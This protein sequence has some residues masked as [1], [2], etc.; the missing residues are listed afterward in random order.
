[1]IWEHA[2]DYGYQ[3]LMGDEMTNAPQR[4]VTDSPHL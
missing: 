1:M 3:M 2:S 4:V